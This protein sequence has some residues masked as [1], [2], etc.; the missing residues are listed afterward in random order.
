MVIMCH[1]PTTPRAGR[2]GDKE[3]MTQYPELGGSTHLS[4]SLSLGIRT[5]SN[6]QIPSSAPCKPREKNEFVQCHR[7]G[8]EHNHCSKW[9]PDL[10]FAELATTTHYQWV[11]IEQKFEIFYKTSKYFYL[12]TMY[13]YWNHC[14]C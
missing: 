1:L 13:L 4:S 6:I 14:I 5:L 11:K 8:K 9:E 3:A 7:P 12:S 10:D 2:A